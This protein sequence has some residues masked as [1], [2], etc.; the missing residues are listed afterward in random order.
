MFGHGCHQEIFQGEEHD[1]QLNKTQFCFSCGKSKLWTFRTFNTRQKG[2]LVNIRAMA[3]KQMKN[4]STFYIKGYLM[5]WPKARG[6]FGVFHR[7]I[8]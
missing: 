2:K 7:I 4:Y 8:A 1:F 5:R 6:T 3:T